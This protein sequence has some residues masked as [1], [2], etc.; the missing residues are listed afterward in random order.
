MVMAAA[1]WAYSCSVRSANLGQRPARA[2][3]A[4][5]DDRRV[6][7]TAHVEHP[8]VTIGAAGYPA[9]TMELKRKILG[10]NAA[11][12]YGI[13]VQATRCGI[14]KS[15]LAAAKRVLDAERG[16]RRWSFVQPVLKSRRE[17]FAL[18]RAQGF[19]PG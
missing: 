19:R 7:S 14:D 5:H 6:F 15:E 9:L 4:A 11:K 18:K 1:F 10:L 8:L 3:D 12:A 16:G 13:Q 2:G 17:F